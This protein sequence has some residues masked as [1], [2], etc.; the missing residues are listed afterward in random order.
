MQIVY[1]LIANENNLYL[2]EFWVSI[3][4]VR[5]IHSD[6][7]IKVLVDVDTE[8]MII[9]R[10]KLMALISE[11]IVVPTPRGYNA[12]QRSRQIKT[13]I[14]EII[15]GPFLFI[16]TDTVVCKSLMSI[17]E[18]I[19]DINLDENPILAVPDGHLPLCVSLRLA[20]DRAAYRGLA[21]GGAQ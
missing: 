6:I 12:K 11:M 8:K 21:F 9:S 18:I 3:F 7:N 15:K 19:D 4:S 5:L 2:E 10:P 14:R 16:D 1:V 20:A 17:N 13:S